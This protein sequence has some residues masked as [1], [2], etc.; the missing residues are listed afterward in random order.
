MFI[1][2]SE[3]ISCLLTA[4]EDFD[5]QLRLSIARFIHLLLENAQTKVQEIVLT[6]PTALSKVVDLLSDPR[7]VIRNEAIILLIFLSHR[8]TP[9]QKLIAFEGVFE[10][11]LGIIEDEGLSDGLIVVE[12][13]INLIHQLLSQN[14]SNLS[15]FLE[16]GYTQQIS[17]FFNFSTGKQ[18]DWSYQKVNNVLQMLNL[19]QSL[20]S[21]QNPL[22]TISAFQKILFK[23]GVLNKMA[24]IVVS[25]EID[26]KVLAEAIVCIGN[27]IANNR[28]NQNFF[29]NVMT[30][31]SPPK[32]SILS[33][34][35]TMVNEKQ[36]LPLRTAI[37]YCF[38]SYLLGNE[39]KKADII[40]T[41]LPSKVDTSSVTSG[42]LLCR[43][44][45]SRDQTSNWLCS[46]ALSY[47]LNDN[48]KEKLLRVQLATSI[49]NAPV[50]LMQ[51]AVSILTKND[52]TAQTKIGMMILLCTWL[53][54]CPTAV[55][56]L[57]RIP[58]S[59]SFFT[60]HLCDT[61][62]YPKDIDNI[63]R[64]LAA[65]LLGI[66]YLYNEDNKTNC[67]FDRK[68][69]KHIVEKRM[70][71]EMFKRNMI[72]IS[73]SE[74]FG[75]SC[76]KHYMNVSNRESLVLDFELVTLFKS[77]ESKIVDAL[78]GAEN[79]N[80]KE[81]EALKQEI[82]GLKDTVKSQEKIIRNKDT[83]ISEL[84]Q[85]LADINAE[86]ENLKYQIGV[87]S[88][89]TPIVTSSANIQTEV[90]NQVPNQP[91][92]NVNDY[93]N[94]YN[95]QNYYQQQYALVNGNAGSYYQNVTNNDYPQTAPPVDV[96]NSEEFKQ[97]L[98]ENT[99]LKAHIENYNSEFSKLGQLNS[100]L[101]T[102]VQ[103]L[104]EDLATKTSENSQESEKLK[105]YESQYPVLQ[106]QYEQIYTNFYELQNQF[107]QQFD[108]EQKLQ[109]L[110]N[111]VFQCESVNAQWAQQNEYLNQQILSQNNIA[112]ELN[113]NN[114]ALKTQIEDL[115]SRIAS[116][117]D[118]KQELAS[119]LEVLSKHIESNAKNGNQNLLIETELTA[120]LANI[121]M[122]SVN[123]EQ[124]FVVSQNGAMNEGIGS[125]PDVIG[126]PSYETIEKELKDLRSDQDDLLLLLADQDTKIK[127][128]K[129][130][131]KNRNEKLS[132][133]K[134]GLVA[135]GA[136]SLI[137]DEMFAGGE[138]SDEAS[139]DP[140]SNDDDDDDKESGKLN[141]SANGISAG[142]KRKIGLFTPN[143]SNS[144][145][146]SSS[147]S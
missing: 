95:Y 78:S 117:Q 39:D 94:G 47:A 92:S 139:D 33:L 138:Q 61:S 144:S 89:A 9:M 19:V 132:A 46:V 24:V 114:E 64:A 93:N 101:K 143:Q 11:V 58:A 76:Q 8:N 81:I 50:T 56:C 48:Q 88:T 110:Q 10:T 118:D 112:T 120:K 31:Q 35:M 17:K 137:G 140:D 103:K 22:Q 38:H 42:Q 16:G 74:S 73:V 21:P 65:F 49:G 7:E 111:K 119:E 40:N 57:L 142:E 69:L 55:S 145:A 127:R 2:E 6:S 77:L 41:L 79:E 125:S 44:L 53:H 68:S 87:I 106:Q 14:N 147:C 23:H 102:Q 36:E 82:V 98:T 4:L 70:G 51:H 20:V 67:E 141:G 12:D 136:G 113:T 52:S 45:F 28:T 43:G 134:A 18:K 25:S 91:V 54:N 97:M 84:D 59:I 129:R 121:E 108:P 29:E 124:P 85:K 26:A 133:I 30:L 15:F 66:C 86:N 1:K 60:S 13:C 71:L 27:L 99:Q 83:H 131:V 123:N 62:M 146:T 116:L 80:S 72:L 105:W 96:K 109:E 107:N 3:V 90:S 32:P 128:L 5:F 63:S 37:L 135:V 75:K 122:Q 34:L 126:K 115:N 130:R 104:N 100:E